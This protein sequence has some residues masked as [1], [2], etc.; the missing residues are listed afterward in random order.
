MARIKA[1]P[2][3]RTFSVFNYIFLFGLAFICIV[4]LLNVLA[5]SLSSA[6]AISLGKVSLWPVEPTTV[7]YE[8]LI[9]NDKFWR[10]MWITIQRII[11]GGAVNM[12]LAVMVAYPLSKNTKVFPSRTRYAWYFLFTILFG[13]GLIPGFLV[14]K[15]TGLINSIW[16]L[17]IPGAVPVYNI[18]L[19][20]NF[21]R[22]LPKEMEEAAFIDGA[23]HWRTLWSIYIPTSLPA[24]ATIGLFTLVG[25]WNDWFSAIIYMRRTE[26]YPLQTYLQNVVIA[27]TFRVTNP[28]DV[29]ILNKLSNRTISSAQIFIG[30]V[31]ILFAY[32]PLQ[33][34]FT[35]GIVL[36]SVKG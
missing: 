28:N 10:S 32:I 12:L 36:G 22:Q 17:V 13:G 8:F 11:L 16:A 26:M 35:K 24:L 30:M 29:D 25:H 4:P 23:G 21:F 7:A 18:I 19:L 5:M 6:M 15:Y 33:K 31:P 1:T 34:Y 2:A 14:V 27:S 3:Y 9:K 20:L